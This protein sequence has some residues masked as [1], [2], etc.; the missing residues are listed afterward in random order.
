MWMV[1]WRSVPLLCQSL[2]NRLY[3]GSAI[4][5]QVFRSIH[6]LK[7]APLWET[8]SN[9][10]YHEKQANTFRYKSQFSLS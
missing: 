7:L 6:S 5:L 3:R 9:L 1:Q 8:D 10:A 4:Y 2:V